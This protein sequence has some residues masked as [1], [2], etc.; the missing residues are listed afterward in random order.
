MKLN[1]I[2]STRNRLKR[3][4]RLGCGRAC[5]HGETS[6]RGN[7]GGNARSG[8]STPHNFSGIPWYRKFPKRGFNRAN[9]KKIYYVLNLGRLQT[10]LPADFSAVVD[11]KALL[12]FGLIKE[13][14]LPI[15][16][17]GEGEWKH[18]LSIQVDEVSKGAKAKIEAAG[19]KVVGVQ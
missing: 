11:R 3:R 10:V 15:K 2:P 14:L 17:L 7:K 12:Q 1:K 19:G 8:Y 5:G 13:K 16:I 18:S 9:F 4:K 6:T